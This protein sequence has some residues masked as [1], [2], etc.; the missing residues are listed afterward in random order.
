MGYNAASFVVTAYLPSHNDE[1]DAE[2]EKL[3]DSLRQE[4]EAITRKPQYA[5]LMAGV[6]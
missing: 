3:W 2:G 6:V 5:D 4:V 1:R